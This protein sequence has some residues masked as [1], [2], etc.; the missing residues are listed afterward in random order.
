MQ[1]SVGHSFYAS[2]FFFSAVGYLGIDYH[3][4]Q[5]QI[6]PDKAELFRTVE[7]ELEKALFK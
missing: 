4:M 5:K 3:G 7:G 1:F 6:G 2:S